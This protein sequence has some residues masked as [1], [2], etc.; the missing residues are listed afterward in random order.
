MDVRKT[1]AWNLRR[2]RVEQG[3]TQERLAL[4]CGIDRSYMG[5]IERGSENVSV[6]TLEAVSA[7]LGVHVS[8]L[9]AKVEEGSPL[10]KPMP[11]GRKSKNG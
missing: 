10:P 4:A 3:F 11:A 5:R 9:F 7:A 1:I 8:E 2:L 6:K